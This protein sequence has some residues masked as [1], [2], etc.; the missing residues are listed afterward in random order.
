MWELLLSATIRNSFGPVSGVTSKGLLVFWEGQKEDCLKSFT[1]GLGR[2]VHLR[3]MTPRL[4]G[5]GSPPAP[6]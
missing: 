3:L 1:A 5:P 2:Q 4:D 6:G